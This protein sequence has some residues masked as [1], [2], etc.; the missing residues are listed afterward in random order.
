MKLQNK[1][2]VASL[3]SQ[4]EELKK[5][6]SAAGGLEEKAEQKKVSDFTFESRHVIVLDLHMELQ[7]KC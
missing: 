1:A 2:K 3:T 7:S 6:L 4:L 5:Q